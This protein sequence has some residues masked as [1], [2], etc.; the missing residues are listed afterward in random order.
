MPI[1]KPF[2][3]SKPSSQAFK[4]LSSFIVKTS[5][6]LLDVKPSELSLGG[7]KP[8]YCT[9]TQAAQILHVSTKTLRRWDKAGKIRCIRTAGGHRRI[10]HSELLRLQQPSPPHLPRSNHPW[11]CRRTHPR[12]QC[13]RI[14]V[15]TRKRAL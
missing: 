6:A 2:L 15:G 13:L 3:T 9:I 11:Q 1:K 7:N 4:N 10:P 14:T 12:H 5:S 8:L